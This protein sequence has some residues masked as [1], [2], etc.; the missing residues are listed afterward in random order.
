MEGGAGLSGQLRVGYCCVW[1]EGLRD[2]VF[3]DEVE[4]EVTVELVGEG[5]EY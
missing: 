2:A 1:G 4:R 3:V 5:H